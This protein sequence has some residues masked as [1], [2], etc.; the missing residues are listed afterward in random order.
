M[1][2]LAVGNYGMMVRG[3]DDH[4]AIMDAPS[5]QRVLAAIAK[6]KELVDSTH[7]DALSALYLPRERVYAVL[8]V[9]EP[10]ADLH[11]H[12][13]SMADDIARRG[14]LIDRI[15]PLHVQQ[16]QRYAYQVESREAFERDLAE[17]RSRCATTT[18][19]PEPH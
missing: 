17:W 12:V 14:L 3:F 11:P 9:W 16:A 7:D 8:D 4:V 18:T 10:H 13:R 15:V 5:E 19:Y 1:W 2:L 6:S